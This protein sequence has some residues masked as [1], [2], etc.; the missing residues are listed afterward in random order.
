MGVQRMSNKLRD[1]LKK[2]NTEIKKTGQ[3]VGLDPILSK[4]IILVTP[5]STIS[6]ALDVV[7]L[8]ADKAE[9]HHK[10]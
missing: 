3:D 1:G 7:E 2:V 10:K 8:I 9:K 4:A 5:L 6:T